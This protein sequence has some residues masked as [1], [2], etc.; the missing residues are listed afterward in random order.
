MNV[1]YKLKLCS[2]KLS[3]GRCQIKFFVTAPSTETDES[4]YGYMLAESGST[5]RE[6]VRQIE[7]E[8]KMIGSRECLYPHQL[9]NLGQRNQQ[10]SPI[11]LFR[12]S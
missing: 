2:K 7:E 6:V 4:Y 8:M 10:R 1:G 9:F 12:Q 3:S 5:L 11:Y